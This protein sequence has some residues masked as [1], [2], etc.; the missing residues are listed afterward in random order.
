MRYINRGINLEKL[1]G[2][3]EFY[4][5]KIKNKTLTEKKRN[6]FLWAL[7]AINRLIEKEENS[8]EKR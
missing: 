4:I 2:T 8:R 7:K 6:S 5:Q 3:R 1:K